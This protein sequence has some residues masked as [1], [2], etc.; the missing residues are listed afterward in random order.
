MTERILGPRGP[1][2][3]RRMLLLLPLAAV[4]ALLL[5]FGAGATGA[6]GTAAGFEDDDG[7]LVVESS[8]DWN[9]FAP[10]TWEGTAPYRQSD[11]LVSGWT[12]T[13]IEDAQATNDDTAFA[14]GSKQDDNCPTINTGKAPNKDD[15]KRIYLATKNI[16]GHTYLMLAWV[17]IPQNTTSSS[18]H[19][20]FEFN[21]GTDGPCGGSSNG[22]VQRVAGDMLIVYDFEGGSD[23]PT[24]TIRRWV[25]S[26]ACEV[27][28][29]SPPCWGPATNLTDAGYAEAAVNS[30]PV[31]DT[32][33]PDTSET[34][35]TS[36]FG[37]A[38][39]DLTGAGVFG[40]GTCESFGSAFG[41]SRSSGNS[42]TAQM[43]D[44]VGPA[45]FTL[46]NCGT[47]IVHKTTDP[48]GDT[49]TSFGYTTDVTTTPATTPS[50]FSLKDGETN[51]ITNVN[52]GSGLSVTEDDPSPAYALE[53]IDCSSSTVPS[54]NISTD[55]T[56]R[57]VTFSIAGGETLECTFTN[58]LQQGAI[59]ITK[60]S[61]KDDGGLA[62]ATFSITGPNSYSNSVSSGSDGTVC[63]DGL[64]F[65]DYDVTET[66]APNGYAVDDTSTHTLTVDTDST[67]GD[68]N[69]VGISFSDTP[70][71]EIGVT[72]TSLAG[73]DVTAASI[74]CETGSTTVDAV[75]ENG[76]ADP[77]YDDTDET[78][79]DLEPGTYTCTVVIDP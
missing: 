63:V 23:T 40:E 11:A 35:G 54:G 46:S 69:E 75:A 28:N 36:E 62:G 56:T 72:F 42:G 47:V 19:V 20:G 78:F 8:F 37:E 59:E 39:V 43:K 32:I 24:I 57:A 9:G 44:L 33:A 61:S 16:S 34:L 30:G 15:L 1:R 73:E 25:E 77:A 17:R 26:G 70:L 66:A 13:G 10:T 5:A 67:C 2:R 21:K 58:K 51:T 64:S 29:S 52:P 50:P 53:S 18:A 4:A 68:G 79:T 74:A 65:G 71:S 31:S 48:A 3:R 27:G 38:G 49:S 76:S 22:L 55:T 41:V 60:T 12:F 6:V 7:N 14:G 45:D